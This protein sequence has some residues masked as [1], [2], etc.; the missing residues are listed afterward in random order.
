MLG[1][2]CC[3]CCFVCSKMDGS[4]SLYFLCGREINGSAPFDEKISL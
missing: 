2:Y 3:R 4:Q 1:F